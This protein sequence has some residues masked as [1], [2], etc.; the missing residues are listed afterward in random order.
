MILFYGDYAHPDNEANVSISRVGL[1]AED[2]FVYAYTEVWNITG[3]LH[4]DTDAALFKAMADLLDAYSKQ[5]ENLVWKK[6]DVVMHQLLS[7][8]TLTGTKVSTLPHFPKNTGG[9]LTTFRT[10]NIVVEAE[11][12]FVPLDL[13]ADPFIPLILKYEESLN[14]TGSG[15]P[16]VAFLPTLTGKYQKQQLTESSTITI[17]QSGM[18]VG[19]GAYPIPNL[20]LWPDDEHQ[21]RRQ[22]NRAP[23]RRRNGVGLEYPIHWNYTFERN[24]KFPVPKKPLVT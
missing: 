24:D 7:D 17:V 15:G 3:I 18:S 9:E 21:D 19:L 11:V 4:G 16:K 1:E 12:S 8:D 20:P 5:G 2:G 22:I 13:S 14:S 6:G 23:T 10:Y